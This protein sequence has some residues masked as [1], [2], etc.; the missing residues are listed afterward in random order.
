MVLSLA[1]LELG[2]LLCAL[3]HPGWQRVMTLA[4]TSPASDMASDESL[5][6]LA[7]SL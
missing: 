5:M 2:L 4:P 1:G 6:V 3:V 7:A